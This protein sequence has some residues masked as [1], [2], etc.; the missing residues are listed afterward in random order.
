MRAKKYKGCEYCNNKELP[1]PGGAHEFLI[2]DNA[3][4][5]Y[6]ATDGWEGIVIEYCPWCGRKLKG[7]DNGN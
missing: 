4:Y 5:Y 6:D 1:F 3:M 2:L 7:A